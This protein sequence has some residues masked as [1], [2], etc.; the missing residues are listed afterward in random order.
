MKRS[1]HD[2]HPMNTQNAMEEHQI[3]SIG[4]IIQRKLC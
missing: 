2:D 3:E 1:S 4:V